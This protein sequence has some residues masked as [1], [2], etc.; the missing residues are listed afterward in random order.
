MNDFTVLLLP[1]AF[2]S[3]VALTLD[4]LSCAA[5]L[6]PRLGLGAPRWRVC[7][8]HAGRVRLG[9]GLL[10]EVEALDATADDRSC[11]IL[12]GLGLDSPEAIAQRLQHADVAPVLQPCAITCRAARQSRRP[13]PP[14][15]CC[16]PPG[17]CTGAG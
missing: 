14:C 6:A 5:L 4:I 2:A 16:R 9:Q 1:G 17:C 12:P 3:S 11:W 7:A 10:L 13:V 8:L 15:S